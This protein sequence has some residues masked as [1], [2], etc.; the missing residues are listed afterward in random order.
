MT[1]NPNPAY[2]PTTGTQKTSQLGGPET[3]DGTTV[4]YDATNLANQTLNRYVD[5][6]GRRWITIGYTVSGG[7]TKTLKIYASNQDDGTAESSVEY[8]DITNAYTGAASYT[9]TTWV[10][11]TQP[12]VAKWIKIEVV[13]TGASSDANVRFRARTGY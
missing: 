8:R 6:A 13:I 9:A 5:M 4:A 3:L 12:I 7:G 10:R 1:Y 11:T 2:D